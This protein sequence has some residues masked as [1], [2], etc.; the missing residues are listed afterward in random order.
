V[1]FGD[2][3][4]IA[5]SGKL[6]AREIYRL[7]A[8]FAIWQIWLGWTKSALAGLAAPS[9]TSRALSS[10]VL[11]VEA[12]VRQQIFLNR[13]C[14]KGGDQLNLPKLK[15]FP[16]FRAALSLAVLQEQ[17]TMLHYMKALDGTLY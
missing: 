13:P 4:G 8:C 6:L 10:P 15:S 12:F 16:D 14:G 17:T 11:T 9:R 5:D 2:E 3:R 7:L 1:K